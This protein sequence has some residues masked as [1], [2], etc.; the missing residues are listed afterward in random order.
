MKKK[1]ALLVD[2][3]CLKKWQLDALEI[4]KE[5]IEIVLIINCQNTYTKRSYIKN[6]L[7]YILNILSLKNHFSK[8]KKI[9]FPEIKVVS[10]HSIYEGNWQILPE[11]IHN[12]LLKSKVDLIIKFGMNLMRLNQKK[13]L[14]PV[15][16][17]H[18]G[19]PSKYRGRPSGF[20]EILNNEKFIGIIVQELT[21]QLDAGNIYA[22]AK[23]KIVN[24]SYKKTS[25]NFYSNSAPLLNK[26]I[27]NLYN[28]NIIERN[29]NGRNYQLPSNIKVLFFLFILISNSIKKLIYGLFFE[30]KWKVAISNNPPLLKNNEVLYL[31]DFKKLPISKKYN[32]YADPFFSKNDYKIRVE[33]LNKKTGLGEIIEIDTENFSNQI[34]I[35]SGNHYAYPF[36]F[37]YKNIEYLMPEVSSHT[38]QYFYPLE[39][40]SDEKYYLKGLEHKRIYDSTLLQQENKCFIFFGERHNGDNVLNLWVSKSPF[41]LFVPHPMSPITISPTTARMGG[42]IVN[43]GNRLIRFGQ[44]NSIEYGQSLAIL[45][46]KKLSDKDYNEIKI[47]SISIDNFT[48]PHT[49]NFNSDKSKVLIDYYTTEFSFFAGLRRLKAKMEKFK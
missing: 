33:A 37:K 21:N 20:Y 49:I 25:Q 8:K 6:F 24:F 45:E 32:F 19:D 5:S 4:A 17:Y 42:Q 47:G 27:K 18:H 1:A 11:N 29:V 9:N 3:M 48:G 13:P 7:Y 16:S 43:Y 15:L 10:F 44:N 28:N 2:N 36:S 12:E 38:A 23:S 39:S 26:A 30:K 40:K 22:F 31:K 14:P 41:D 35:K 34:L 46:I